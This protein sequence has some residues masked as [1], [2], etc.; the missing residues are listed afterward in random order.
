MNDTET[1]TKT[2]A[3]IVDEGYGLHRMAM[4]PVDFIE[5]KSAQE[6]RKIFA[7]QWEGSWQ[8]NQRFRAT[9]VSG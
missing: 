2:F 5:A 7:H 3:I 6:A 8:A 4:S 1:R 9:R